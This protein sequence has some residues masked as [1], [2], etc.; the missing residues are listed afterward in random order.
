[1]TPSSLENDLNTEWRRFAKEWLF[2]WYGLTCKGGE[3]DVERFDG[4]RIQFAGVRPR[5]AVSVLEPI[6]SVSNSKCGG[7][8][9]GGARA[10]T[11]SSSLSDF[12]LFT[13]KPPER[14][15]E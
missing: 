10:V 3:V 6:S 11:A 8:A 13:V 2:K 15:D 12:A 7:V 4:G 5:R 9:T 14:P 1:M